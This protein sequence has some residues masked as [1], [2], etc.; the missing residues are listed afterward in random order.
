MIEKLEY[1]FSKCSD[2]LLHPEYK[3]LLQELYTYDLTQELIDF[4]CDKTTSKKHWCEIR[5]EHLKIL[6]L[7][8]SA[9][10]YDLKT[11]Y[12]DCLKKCRRLWLKMFFI[13]GYAVYATEEELCPVMKKFQEQLTKNHDYIDYEHI[14]S[15]A[16]LPYL[17]NTYGY[18]C[19][20]D[21]LKT[22]ENEY[23]KI[24]PLL[25]GYFTLN[26]NLEQINLI[27]TQEVRKR[28][29]EFTLLKEN[30]VSYY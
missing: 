12:F 2:C 16:G 26:E 28:S 9:L 20:E 19:F 25:R 7:N 24:H 17:V 21:T 23:Q 5:F 4:L 18:A 29:E 27:S 22:A 11:F 15:V 3:K 30:A 1:G 14:L 8:K 13:R 6:L 10:N